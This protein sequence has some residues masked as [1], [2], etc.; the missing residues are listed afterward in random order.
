M[1]PVLDAEQVLLLLPANQVTP[2]RYMQ[3]IAALQP[4]IFVALADE[5][6]AHAAAADLMAAAAV[7]AAAAAAAAAAVSSISSTLLSGE[8]GFWSI[9]D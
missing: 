4:D 7:A 9:K 3:A 1:P 5:V 2:E 8:S 6:Q